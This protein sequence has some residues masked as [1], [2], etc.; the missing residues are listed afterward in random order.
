[1]SRP[2]TAVPE[3]HLFSLIWRAYARAALLPLLCVEVLLVLVYLWTNASIRE[4]NIKHMHDVANRGLL[5]VTTGEAR[6]VGLRL[7]AAERLLEVLRRKVA[8]V[9]TSAGDIAPAERARHVR[10]PN[11]VIH[12]NRDNGGAAAFFSAVN[13]TGP[14]QVEK[15]VQLSRIDPTLADVVAADP[16]VVQAYYNTYDSANRIYPYF[17]TLAQY[18]PHLDIPSY[19][20]YYEADATH[21]PARRAVWTDAY[22][23]PA[24]QG[25]MTSVIAPVYRGDFLEGVVG[26]DVTIGSIVEQVLGLELPWRGYALLVDRDGFILAMPGAAERELGLTE[27]KHHDYATAITAEARKPEE[28]RLAAHLPDLAAAL[29]AKP[30]GVRQ[31]ALEGGKIVAWS[32]VEGSGWNLLTVVAEDEVYAEAREIEARYERLGYLIIAAMIGFYLLFF[33]YL[34]WRSRVMSRRIAEPLERLSATARAIG[35]GAYDQHPAASGVLELDEALQQLATMG[36]E[37]GAAVEALTAAKDAAESANQAKSRFLSQ[38]SHEL[39]TP[40]NAVIGFASLLDYERDKVDPSLHENIDRIIEGG[41]HQLA[42]VNEVLDLGRIES[43]RVDFEPEDVV[44]P[45]VVAQVTQSLQ[46]LIAGRDI[47]LEDHSADTDIEMVHADPA[48]LRQVLVNLF[49][50]AVKYNRHGGTID[51]RLTAGEHPGSARLSISDQ[52]PGVPP[53]ERDRI[54]EPFQRLADVE[55]IEGSGVGLA[56]CKSLVEAMGGRIGVH[57]NVD[58]GA[59]FWIEL[60][61]AAW[62]AGDAT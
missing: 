60:P 34:Y 12:T 25:W 43:G 50:N 44:L 28:F 49:S 4:D 30:H 39:R 55:N 37:L 5:G 2:S 6:T 18:D 13:P 23:D 61:L 56:I 42:L 51:V 59:T 11:G 21:D 19:N 47:R 36:R 17:D 58:G 54:F 32:R 40:L 16:L 35:A 33:T 24:G 9:A 31:V 10:A 1:M 57:D 7:Q 48:R 3:R 27:L 26:L 20:F 38:M 45:L 22:V 8:R 29:A 53:A 52:G 41:R 62:P 14:E 46:P 15:L